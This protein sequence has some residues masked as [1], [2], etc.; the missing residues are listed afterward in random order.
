[1]TASL[2]A[3]WGWEEQEAAGNEFNSLGPSEL[4]QQY[5][6]LA[7]VR[8]STKDPRYWSK[9]ADSDVIFFI[10]ETG[11]AAMLPIDGN[12]D[13]LPNLRRLR[14][15]AFVA[16]SHYSTYP[17]TNRALF[18]CFTSWYP[19]S[20]M[21]D[22]VEQY[23]GMIAPGIIRDLSIRGY[24]TATY[25]PFP[26]E[27]DYDV[28]ASKAFGFEHL[29]FAH[30]SAGFAGTYDKPWMLRKSYDLD[31]LHLLE[32]D[33]DGWLTRGEHFAA[34]FAPQIGHDHWYDVSPYGHVKN[35]LD[36]GRPLM[37]LQDAYLG[38]LLKLLESHHRL[39]KTLIVVTGDHG[40][41][42]RLEDPDLQVGMID[43]ISYHVPMLLYAPQILKSSVT[44]PWATSHIDLSPSL[45]DLLGIERERGL[46]QGSPI[47]E[48]DLQGRTTFFFGRHYFSADGYD[49]RSHF[50]MWNHFF[51]TVYENEHQR[52]TS[53]N[54]VPR[55][56]P[57]YHEVTSTIQRMVD[58]QQ[59]WVAV[60]GRGDRALQSPASAM[61]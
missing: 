38:E 19:S 61:K 45:L 47:W 28:K 12:L 49:S 6:D 46:E 7:H 40:A 32:S 22:F 56:S 55:N 15:K 21:K 16:P 4:I 36:R 58:L 30:D 10:F 34:V 48:P 24:R 60:L 13:D 42:T 52:F 26:W 54:E 29:S 9:A 23:P 17:Y 5:R 3:F 14:E 59:R 11:P 27:A 41:R 39:E 33:V 35:P 53:S 43:D 37:A 1:L 31:S 2:R 20:Q 51:D 57:T 50:F 25:S 8:P 18:S 44:I